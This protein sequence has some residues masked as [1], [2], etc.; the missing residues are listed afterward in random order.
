MLPQC[1]EMGQG[2]PAD[3]PR[4]V[5]AADPDERPGGLQGEDQQGNYIKIIQRNVFDYHNEKPSSGHRVGR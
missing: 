5:P 2:Q 1:S 4:P 3:P